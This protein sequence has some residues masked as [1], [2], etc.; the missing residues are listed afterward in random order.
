[1]YLSALAPALGGSSLVYGHVED[2]NINFGFGSEVFTRS[3]DSEASAFMFDE[4]CALS[5][6]TFE[7]T[8]SIFTVGSV[9]TQLEG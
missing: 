5:R 1:M 3:S 2:V 8:T 6:V 4:N 7:G 9:S